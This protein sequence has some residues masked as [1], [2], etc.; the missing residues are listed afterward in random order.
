D[1]LRGRLHRP[2]PAGAGRRAPGH[3][4]GDRPGLGGDRLVRAQ[5][6]EGARSGG[7]REIRAMI[8]RERPVE[9]AGRARNL[10]FDR[11]AATSEPMRNRRDSL[12]LAGLGLS[13]PWATL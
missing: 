7:R 12:L 9:A 4:G 11:P 1:R 13:R 6:A 3:P 10:L 5:V 8:L 2:G